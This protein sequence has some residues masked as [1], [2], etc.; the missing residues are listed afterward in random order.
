MTLMERQ[1]RVAW[2]ISLIFVMGACG[3]DPIGP[4]DNGADP[5]TLE[6]VFGAYTAATITTTEG[7]ITT[8]QL[9]RGTTLDLTLNA[10]G[11]TSGRLF[12]P[13]GNEDGGDLDADLEGT[14]SFDEANGEVTF[15]QAADTFVRDMVFAAARA[16]GAVQLEGQRAFGSTTVRVVLQ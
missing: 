15:E 10:D 6:E 11:S 13:D 14:F 16:N 1:T 7:G 5:I 3:E 4:E 2:L 9:A 12:V 8:D